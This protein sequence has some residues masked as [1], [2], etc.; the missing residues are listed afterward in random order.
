[1]RWNSDQDGRYGIM[2]I[3]GIMKGITKYKTGFPYLIL[4]I[5]W[6]IMPLFFNTRF[7]LHM[8]IV[9]F[10]RCTGAVGLRTVALSGNLSFA[11][12]GFLGVG[13]YAAATMA[14]QGG[15]PPYLSIPAAAA[16]TTAL[17]IVTGFPF[18]RLRSIYFS[19]GTM[20][21]GI[22][23]IFI[24]SAL[25]A[26]GGST[27][28]KNIPPLFGNAG[29]VANYYFFFA[30]VIISCALMYRFEFSRI[31]VT[32][33]AL[34]QS[35]DAAA[36]M[37][38]NE[39]LYR[40][41]AV[42]FGTF[43]TALAGAAYA[44]YNTSLSPTSFGMNMTLLFIVYVMVGGKDSFIG[45]IIG[46]I[47]MVL[48]PE[49]SRA[50]SQFAPYM[51]VGALLIVAYVLPGGLASMPDVINKAIAKRRAGTIIDPAGAGGKV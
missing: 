45:P 6:A 11:Q 29:M 46:T 8:F 47:L 41:L 49:S 34:A 35:S 50:L 14:I 31:G 23:I 17:A 36:A 3:M 44:H 42:G 18:V 16:L 33:R 1:M 22:A 28:L 43:F 10:V 15:V 26:M 7:W 51:S 24:I 40:L 48:I 21:L 20:F 13:A 9:V 30:L 2:G 27:G 37:G 25:P 19:M 32:L 5:A 38:V 39:V 4:I 12:A